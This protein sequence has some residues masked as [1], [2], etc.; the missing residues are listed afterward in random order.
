MGHHTCTSQVRTVPT[1]SFD[2][3]F[4]NNK[5]IFTREDISAGEVVRDGIKILVVKDNKTK[6]VFAHV[7]PQ[8]G[9]DDKRY[10]VDTVTEDVVWLGHTRVIV[11]SD[12]EPAILKL[13]KESLR[14]LRVA[15][16]DMEQVMEEHPPPY[17]S[18]A[19]GAIESAVKQVRGQ[20]KTIRRCLEKRFGHKIP[21]EH[22]MLSWMARMLP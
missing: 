10:V 19:N 9:S 6:S 14:D 17:D 13:V 3:L 7:V 22:A 5:G 12:N 20:F 11:K 15:T 18:Q 8:K 2:Y 16:A 21:V 4:V 1:I